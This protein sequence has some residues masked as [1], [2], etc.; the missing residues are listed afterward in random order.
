ME[1]YQDCHY[2]LTGPSVALYS[3]QDDVTLQC[4]ASQTGLGVALLQLQQ[5][6]S[7]ASRALTQTETMYAQIEKELLAI[8]FACEKFNQCIFG[9]D[10]VYVG[11]DHKPL[12]EIFK[13]S[14]CDAPAR[15]QCMLLR[16]LEVR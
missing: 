7:F 16:L 12:E 13:N 8:V 3:L 14:F 6:V 11:T 10:V 4:N 1:R 2:T 15:L 5:P 9:R